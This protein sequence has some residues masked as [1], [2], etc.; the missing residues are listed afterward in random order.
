M[1]R[2]ELIS[3]IVTNFLSFSVQHSY[4]NISDYD[5]IYFLRFLVTGFTCSYVTFSSLVVTQVTLHPAILGRFSSSSFSTK[6]TSA[7]FCFSTSLHKFC[8]SRTDSGSLRN[9]TL[10][11]VASSLQKWVVMKSTMSSCLSSGMSWIV[12]FGT[13][14]LS[15]VFRPLHFLHI[16][17][18]GRDFD[19]DHFSLLAGMADQPTLIDAWTAL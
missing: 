9:P 10:L 16:L 15:I 6:A 18:K 7:I 14:P 3:F 11:H 4:T 17:G 8:S 19:R 2:Y 12:K 13:S 5:Y 1:L